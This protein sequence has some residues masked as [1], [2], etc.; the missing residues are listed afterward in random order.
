MLA[1]QLQVGCLMTDGKGG[2]GSTGPPSLVTILTTP[3]S[4]GARAMKVAAAMCFAVVGVTRQR[5][6]PP[7][8]VG[9]FAWYR[10]QKG[11]MLK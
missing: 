7:P 9:R 11:L 2:R 1:C 6:G 5:T 4:V 10:N 3:K 8:K